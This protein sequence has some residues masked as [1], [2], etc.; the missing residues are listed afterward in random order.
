M[1]ILKWFMAFITRW[2]RP[3]VMTF[4]WLSFLKWQGLKTLLL[5]VIMKGIFSSFL[6]L[7]HYKFLSFQTDRRFLKIFL[8]KA[9]YGSLALIKVI[10]NRLKP[11]ALQKSGYLLWFWYDFERF[12][13]LTFK[14]AAGRQKRSFLH[15]SQKLY[16]VLSQLLSQVIC[17]KFY[18]KFYHKYY[19]RQPQKQYHNFCHNIRKNTIT[20]SIP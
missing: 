15:L 1:L 7:N 14:G 12:Q 3:F 20:D 13:Y 19:H 8:L 5:A 16:Q 2:F 6:S 11:I 9:D 18:P 10:E 17:H 4:L